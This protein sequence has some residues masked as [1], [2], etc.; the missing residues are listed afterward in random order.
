MALFQSEKKVLLNRVQK[1]DWNTMDDLQ[2][3][4]TQLNAQELKISDIFWMLCAPDRMVRSYA[5]KYVVSKQLDGTVNAIFKGI[6]DTQGVGRSHLI[7]LL[8]QL[9]QSGEILAHVDKM[10][11]D[12]GRDATV[13]YINFNGEEVKE[14]DK[15]KILEPG[16]YNKLVDG[17]HSKNVSAYYLAWARAMKEKDPK[18]FPVDETT[19]KVDMTGYMYLG[20]PKIKKDKDTGED[21][22]A[23]GFVNF[24]Y[25]F[26][27]ESTQT[28]WHANHMQY[29]EKREDGT[30]DE[31]HKKQPMIVLQSTRAKFAKGYRDFD[32]IIY[33]IGL[34]KN[35]KPD[36]HANT[37]G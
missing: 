14:E 8:P 37:H 27:D 1:H 32:R 11:A 23:G 26:W 35:Y 18:A 12:K 31:R 5:S 3:I 34:Q 21:E 22:Y 10:L 30:P 4:F 19:G 24:D 15:G 13:K 36:A 25:G 28:F 7:Q 9:D 29:P 2:E 16:E 33:A 6:K 17:A 20:Q